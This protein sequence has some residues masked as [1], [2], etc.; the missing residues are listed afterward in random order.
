M[1][2]PAETTMNANS[3][4][5]LVRSANVPM[6]Q[7]PAG[8]RDDD[9]GDPGADVGRL[10]LRVHAREHAGEQAVARHREPDARLAVL[11]DQNSAEH[12]QQR[13]DGDDEAEAVESDGFEGVRHRRVVVERVPMRDAGENQRHGG[14]EDRADDQREHDSARHVALR[15]CGILRRRS[16]PRRSRCR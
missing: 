5:M 1:I 9:A 4:P 14:V 3:V 15:A 16:R 10:V 7:M 8:M 13:A 6:S 11:R 12:A 2:T